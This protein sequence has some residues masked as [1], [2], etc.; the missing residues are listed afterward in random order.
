MAYLV[1]DVNG[2]LALDGE[3]ISGVKTY[4][5]ELE[6][7]LTIYLITA[8]THGKQ[9]GLSKELGYETVIIQKGDEG[10]QK[11]DFVRKL[12]KENVVSIGQGRND[13][14]M[15]KESALGICVLSEEG[16]AIQTVLSA[17]VIV[18]DIKAGLKLL[19][20]PIRLIATLRT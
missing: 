1:C 16:S 3:L 14:E 15:L 6:N 12:G 4:L 10:N 19:L 18:P 8:N 13:A 20:N 17:D 9:A 2:T 11:K 7:H 5:R